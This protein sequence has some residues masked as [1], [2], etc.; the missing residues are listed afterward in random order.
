MN[1][2]LQFSYWI[3]QPHIWLILGLI[4][5][6]ADIFLG[7]VLLPF[8]ISAFIIA[9]LIYADKNLVFVDFIFFESWRD[10][11]I[12]YSVLIVISLIALRYI[13]QS[14]K[15]DKSDINKY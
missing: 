8:S 13:L 2:Y 7:F 3:F 11:L 6:I 5:L 10:I 15:K 1:F 9:A 14:R 4:L 12:Y